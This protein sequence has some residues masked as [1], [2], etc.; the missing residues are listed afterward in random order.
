[1]ILAI[2]TTLSIQNAKFC[3]SNAPFV[4]TGLAGVIDQWI[5]SAD[6]NRKSPLPAGVSP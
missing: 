4:I 2:L 6:W 5:P 1:V 3:E